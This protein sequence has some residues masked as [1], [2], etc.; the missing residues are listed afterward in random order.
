VNRLGRRGGWIGAGIGA[1][2]VIAAVA[3]VL[4]L[5]SGGRDGRDTHDVQV[6]A[7]WYGETAS[8][9][10]VGGVTPVD[11]SAVGDDPATPLSVALSKLKAA[12]AGPMWTAAT[13]V[14][15]TQAV[16]VSGID[17]RVEQLRYALHEAIDG[18][19]A[20]A[21]MSVGSLAAIHGTTLDGSITMTGT[22]LPDG[23]V[24]P[25]S[26]VPE[27]LRAAKEAGFTEVMIPAATRATDVRTGKPVDLGAVA[28]SLGVKVT[29]IASVPAAYARMTGSAERTPGRA[30]PPV[31]PGILRML[32]RRSRSLIATTRRAPGARSGPAQ[33]E[34]TVL[35]AAAERALRRDDP[36]LAFTAA[37]EAAQDADE[38]AASARLGATAGEETLAERADAV[39][40]EVARA[41]RQIRDQVKTVAEM[42]VTTISQLTALPDALAWGTFALTSMDVARKRLEAVPSEQELDEIVRFVAVARFEAATYMATTAESVRFLGGRPITNLERTLG[43]FDAYTDL[44][45]DA[46]DANRRYAESLKLAGEDTYLADLIEQSDALTAGV[47]PAFAD[48]RGPTGRSA[49]R[50]AAAL[51]EYVETTQL[52]NDLTQHQSD[53]LQTPPN[54]APIK[55]PQT[56]QI[57]ARS[58]NQ[59]AN[60]QVRRIAAAGLDPSYVRWNNRWGADLAFRRLP[61]TT[62]EQRLHGLEYQWFAV[63]QARLLMALSDS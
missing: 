37:A 12:G 53:A 29:P 21:L 56:L 1:V 42:P 48:L 32:A 18:P 27:K 52:V 10:I 19:S 7:L 40:R 34:I 22:V 31:D 14:A 36:E 60:A 54:L 61:G 59:I 35:L 9:N 11:I 38:E 20:G 15:G 43:M 16:L 6:E 26:G 41:K 33:R 5:A 49:L 25:V 55:D 17:P 13:T 28:R 30:A 4:V 23:S 50:L 8:G 63:L 57:Q 24:G 39:L 3:I 45:A 58:A 47:H 51:L 44:I 46:A 62:A 2:L